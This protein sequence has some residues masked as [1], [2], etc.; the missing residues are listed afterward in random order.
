M[1]LLD[2]LTRSSSSLTSIRAHLL[3][4]PQPTP[5]IAHYTQS[6]TIPHDALLTLLKHTR[7][8]ITS[9]SLA[10]SGKS[11]LIPA[12]ESQTKKVEDDYS[13]LVAVVLGLPKGSCLSTEWAK[14]VGELGEAIGSL[15]SIFIEDA[16][17]LENPSSSSST[18]SLSTTSPTTTSSKAPPKPYLIQTK[19]IWTHIDHLILNISSSEPQALIKLWR[20]DQGCIKDAFEEYKELLEIDEGVGK[21]VDG[22]DDDGEE[23]ER[24]EEDEQVDDEWADLER[25]LQGGDQE[26][27]TPDERDRIASVSAQSLV[28]G[29]DHGPSLIMF[30]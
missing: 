8:E 24:D 1:T 23:E 6:Y 9:L 21:S 14:E 3:P 18:S 22:D 2:T 29:L 26:E 10:F 13:R 12:A 17:A 19:Q 27:M 4:L 15:F 11:I 20:S 5:T 25:E 30:Y 28:V 7:Q 16:R